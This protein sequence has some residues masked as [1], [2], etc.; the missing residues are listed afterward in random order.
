MA[1]KRSHANNPKPRGRRAG[2]SDTSEAILNAARS[3][4]AQRGYAKATVRAIAHRAGVDP[5]LIRH[6]YGS[7][8]ELFAISVRYPPD[9]VSRLASVIDGDPD[10]LGE[11]FTDAYLSL[12]EDP[13]TGQPLA[14]LIRSA[15]TS[16][17]A[18]QHLRTVTQPD[19]LHQILTALGTDR[20]P[21][22]VALAGA[23]LFGIALAR[24]LLKVEPLASLNRD[25]LIQTC[26][27]VIK[28]YL[29]I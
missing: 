7:K 5:A 24:Y 28:A 17:P 25:Q 11:R 13:A 4:F 2:D 27:P 3:E 19:V 10:R 29:E 12:W 1:T 23:H 16:A 15:M 22:S 6:F 20:A 8:E 26:A 18:A 9:V 21:E 14:A